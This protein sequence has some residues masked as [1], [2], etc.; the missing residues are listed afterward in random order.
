MIT[1]QLFEQRVAVRTSRLNS[2]EINRVLAAAVVSRQFCAL[3][4][5]DPARAIAQGFAGE[6]FSLSTDE[7][8]LVLAARGST[9]SEFAAYLCRYL[10]PSGP[11]VNPNL[12]EN[13]HE[14]QLTA[15]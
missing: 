8:N 14:A 2:T 13:Y 7:Y 6:R 3:L 11:V 12:T 10:P 5:R 9:L 1:S 15:I 4:L